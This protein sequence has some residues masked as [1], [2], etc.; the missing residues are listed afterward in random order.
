MDILRTQYKLLKDSRQV[1]LNYCESIDP[2]HFTTTLESFGHGSIRNLLVHIA[3]TY[4]GWL[5]KFA[6][7]KAVIYFNPDTISTVNDVGNM[8]EQ[9]NE[10][11]DQFLQK[12]AADINLPVT[13]F[14]KEKNA[15]FTA[16]AL[17]LFTH[18]T[19]HEFH[20]KGQILSMSRRLGYTPV[21]TDLLR[22]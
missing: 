3:I 8:F 19:T 16:T 18:V 9:V 10:T 11:T 13:R 22:F 1:L 12:F 2:L 14:I 5:L 21:D 20:H 15:A 6:Q 7:D 17:A 4:Q